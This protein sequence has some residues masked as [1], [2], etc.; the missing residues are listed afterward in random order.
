MEKRGKPGGSGALGRGTFAMRVIAVVNQKGG[1]GKTTTCI[2]LAG[3]FAAKGLRTLLVDMDPQSHCAAGLAIPEQRIDMDIGDAMLLKDPASLDP[4]RLLWRISRKLDLAPSRMRL[5]GLEAP[6]GGLSERPDRERRL[7]RVLERLAASYSVCVIDCSPAIGLLTFNAL[8]AATEVL[9]PVETSYFALQGAAKQVN[10]VKSIER[11]LGVRANCWVLPTMHDESS[12]L[13]RDLL[14]ELRRRFGARVTP[15]VVRLDPALRE[16]ASFGQS[17]IEYSPNSPGAQDYSA[18][19]EWLASRPGG[20]LP[21]EVPVPHRAPAPPLH[22]A[23]AG[24]DTQAPAASLTL[25]EVKPSEVAGASSG[26]SSDSEPPASMVVRTEPFAFEAA[27]AVAPSPL[28]LAGEA[29]DHAAGTTLAVPRSHDQPLSPLVQPGVHATDQVTVFI[30]PLGLGRQICVAGDFNNW[31]PV[32]HPMQPN[33][34]LGVLELRVALPPGRHAYRLVVD[35]RW[36]ADPFN[37][38]IEDNPFAER[39]SIIEVPA[40]A[41]CA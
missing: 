33:E 30:Q 36:T 11:R 16:A 2:N 1:C 18:L 40:P 17:V 3:V 5:A 35:G 29:I 25:Q 15:A 37:R 22:L 12:A 19:G 38:Q 8:T 4:S 21:E 6:R 20:A 26:E 41:A 31:S 23:G 34:H 9:I 39:N 10:T 13:A 28:R 32:A 7:A 24:I 14:E 27:V